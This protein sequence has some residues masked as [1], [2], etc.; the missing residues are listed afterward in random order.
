MNV[1][2]MLTS[3]GNGCGQSNLIAN[4]HVRYSRLLPVVCSSP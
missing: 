1:L 2:Q 3:H 4:W